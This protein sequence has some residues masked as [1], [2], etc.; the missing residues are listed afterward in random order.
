MKIKII[1]LLASLVLTAA[2]ARGQVY[3]KDERKY[4]L[5]K[6]DLVALSAKKISSDAKTIK[7]EVS[8]RNSSPKAAGPFNVLAYCEWEPKPSE[9]STGSKFGGSTVLLGYSVGSLAG[10][11]TKSYVM[12]CTQPH[13]KATR[14]ILKVFVDSEEKV[15]ELS[16]TNNKYSIAFGFQ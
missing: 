16:E 2:A 3:G 4:S 15:A 9:E 5:L 7:I 6:P 8:F 13:P 10:K 11:A 12:Q 1:L 14:A